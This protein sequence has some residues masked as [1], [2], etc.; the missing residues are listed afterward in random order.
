MDK[1]LKNKIAL[2]TGAGRGIG[3]A[4]AIA[5]VREG[6]TVAGTARTGSELESLMR[7]IREAGGT[8]IAIEADLAD[9][10]SPARI[11]SEVLGEFGSVDILV[12]NAGVV[13]AEDPR[14][15][16]SFSDQFWDRTLA[17]NLT[18]V[19]LLCKALLP[20]LLEKKAGRIINTPLRNTVFSV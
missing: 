11:A 10:S 18:A 12:N 5:F 3:R 14:P 4:I 20:T 6:A 2:V 1:A 17:V 19:Y 16:V 15:L 9:V 8:G 13:S 7:E